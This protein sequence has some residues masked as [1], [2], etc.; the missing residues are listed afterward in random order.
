MMSHF[1]RSGL[2]FLFAVA[3]FAGIAPD[4]SQ[5]DAPKTLAEACA[6]LAGFR[7]PDFSPDTTSPVGEVVQL[8]GGVDN[9]S[10]RLIRLLQAPSAETRLDAAAALGFRDSLLPGVIF[11]NVPQTVQ[12]QGALYQRR[13][14]R[15]NQ[16]AIP[17]LTAGVQDKDDS[18]RLAAL[19]ALEALTWNSQDAPW[20]A[21]VLPVSQAV[22]SADTVLYLPALRVLAYMPADV[23]PAASALRSGLHSTVEERNYALAALLHAG[24]TNRNA[25]LNAFLPDLASPFL[26]K[27]RQA[28]ADISQAAVPLWTSDF[29]TQHPLSNWNADSRLS[30]HFDQL[31]SKLAPQAQTEQQAV[32]ARARLLAALVQAASAPDHSL[33]CAAAASLEQI[34]KWTYNGL[35]WGIKP[36]LAYDTRPEVEQSLTR[37][38]SFFEKSEPDWAKRLQEL[39]AKID[40]GP[41][42]VT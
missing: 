6:A 31:A 2:L 15:Y 28:M 29:L 9:V 35:R 1:H 30:A 19:Q 41:G 10:P 40:R 27:R 7:P 3:L 24:Q 39:H 12:S 26:A 38:S 36:N 25:T 5:A 33:R 42:A 34:A 20:S 17:A 13:I 22:T 37:A 11:A 4:K 16:L 32:E 14:E 21:A 18:V 8:C 23:S